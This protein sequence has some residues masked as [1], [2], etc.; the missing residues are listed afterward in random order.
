M[1]LLLNIPFTSCHD[2]VLPAVLP[3][4]QTAERALPRVQGWGHGVVELA[5]GEVVDVGVGGQ[6]KAAVDEDLQQDWLM[7]MVFSYSN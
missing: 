2:N 4:G 5:G 1:I 7:F 6:G 3:G